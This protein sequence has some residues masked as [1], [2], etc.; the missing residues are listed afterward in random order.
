MSETKM[1]PGIRRRWLKALRSGEYKQGVGK[2]RQTDTYGK[3][4]VQR[5]CC[6]GV[7][8][9]LYKK[10]RVKQ[11]YTN[12]TFPRSKVEVLPKSVMAWAGLKQEDP[13]VKNGS[14]AE[15]NDCGVSFKKISRIIERQ[16]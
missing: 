6:L 8:C 5:F 14:L 9:D 1:K 4:P 15:L 12:A 16:L 3:V 7:L 11:G 10:D 2:L 13:D